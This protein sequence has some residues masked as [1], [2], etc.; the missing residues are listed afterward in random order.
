MKTI[1]EKKKQQL[2][3]ATDL[4]AGRILEKILG[5]AVAEEVD[6]MIFDSSVKGAK[7]RFCDAGHIKGEL[8]F[9]SSVRGSIFSALKELSGASCDRPGE[10]KRDLPGG[11]I[12]FSVSLYK[13][14]KEEMIIVSLSRTSFEVLGVCQLGFEKKVLGRVKEVLEEGG[15]G[16]V[17]VTGPFDSGKTSTLYSFISHIN[18][19]E[20]NITTFERQISF[21]LP[22]VNQ[23]PFGDKPGLRQPFSLSSILRQ[24][25]DVVMIDEATDKA[26]IDAALNLSD[27]GYFVLAGLF[28]RKFSSTLDFLQGLDVSLP[29]FVSSVKM[30]VNQRTAARNCPSCLKRSKMDRTSF[31]R[32]KTALFRPGLFEELKERKLVGDGVSG[33]EDIAFYESVGCDKCRGKGSLGRV[34]VF[35][36]LM[37]SDEVVKAIRGGHFSS[38]DLE[39]SRQDCFTLAESALIKAAAGIISPKELLKIIEG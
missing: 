18:S 31:S 16:L 29:L 3:L 30:L 17:L 26:A 19:P 6:E 36:V 21:D 27:R 22:D 4:A 39:V 24:D 7:V 34:G 37:M 5:Y 38:V 20:L 23:S 35:E 14:E 15:K 13:R 8:S 28:G 25:P 10:F 9:P 2:S 33:L 32:M 1:K 12:L 11:K